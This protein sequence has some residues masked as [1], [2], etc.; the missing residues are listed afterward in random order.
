MVGVARL[1]RFLAPL[2]VV[3]GE[4]DKAS[5]EVGREILDQLEGRRRC[6]GLL[7]LAWPPFVGILGRRRAEGALQ[8]G[9]GTESV[10]IDRG[11]AEEINAVEDG[12]LPKV[13]GHRDRAWPDMVAEKSE[14]RGVSA[15][16]ELQPSLHPLAE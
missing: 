3:S 14:E 10:A 4:G 2:P 15:W 9:G 1:P 16:V 13:G 8:I 12:L 7:F 5:L 6:E 11:V